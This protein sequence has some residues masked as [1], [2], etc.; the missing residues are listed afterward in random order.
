MNDQNPNV[1][2]PSEPKDSLGLSLS[3][4]LIDQMLE[5]YADILRMWPWLRDAVLQAREVPALRKRVRELD[6]ELRFVLAAL[7]NEG[8]DA[9]Q[10]VLERSKVGRDNP[11]VCR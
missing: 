9:V 3:D 8:S 5:Y 10:R 11:E 6:T 1:N 2:V 7:T 4:E